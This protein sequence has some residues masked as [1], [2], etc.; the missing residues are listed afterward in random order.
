MALAAQGDHAQLEPYVRRGV[1]SG[2]SRAEIAEA[3]THLAFYAGWG[4]AGQALAVMAA[5]ADR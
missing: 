5:T 2:L 4:K 3:F 1:A